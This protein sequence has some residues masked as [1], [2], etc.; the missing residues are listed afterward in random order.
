MEAVDG[1][2]AGDHLG[3]GEV[4]DGLTLGGVGGVDSAVNPDAE[5]DLGRGGLDRA[6]HGRVGVLASGEGVGLVRCED[7]EAWGD[8]V[9]VG[10]DMTQGEGAADVGVGLEVIEGGV[11]AVAGPGQGCREGVGGLAAPYA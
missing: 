8:G 5:E 10:W 6:A 1:V 9:G 4:C 2:A 3:G 7:V 11:E